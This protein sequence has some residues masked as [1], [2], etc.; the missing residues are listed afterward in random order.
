MEALNAGLA[1]AP[2]L[3]LGAAALW[4]VVSL[5]LSPCHLAGIPLLIGFIQGQGRVDGRAAFRLAGLFVVG[6]LASIALIGLITALLGRI[7]GDLGDWG[8][9]LVAGLFLWAGLHLLELL[10]APWTTPG[11]LPGR[12]GGKLDALLLGLVFGI[13]LGP[14]TFAFMAPVLGV[15]FGSASPGFALALLTAYGLGHGAIIVAAGS[16]V[17]LTQGWLDR[18]GRGVACARRAL[19]LLLVG[20]GFYLFWI[21]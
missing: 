4:G 21:A 12:R 19:G 17:A 14:C 7:A 13:A 9:Y 18:A 15:A 1:S 8:G 16:S 5:L 10:P 11:H 2:W 6:M 20:F 3:A